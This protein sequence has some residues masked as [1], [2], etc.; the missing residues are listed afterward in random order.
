[1]G[2]GVGEGV[3]DG[4][5]EGVGEGLGDGL[6]NTQILTTEPWAAW[7]PAVGSCLVTSPGFWHWGLAKVPTFCTL[8]PASLRSVFA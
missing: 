3:G 8:N 2:D 5:G 6:G 1:V 4:V 7:M